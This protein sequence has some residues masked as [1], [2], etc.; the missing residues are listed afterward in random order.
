MRRR[1]GEAAPAQHD[2]HRRGDIALELGL[3]DARRLEILPVEIGDAVVPQGFERQ[4]A[5][6]GRR[7]NAEAGDLGEDI[8]AEHRRVPGDRRAPVMADNDGLLFAERRHQRDHVA[9]IVEDGVGVDIGRR[10]G[11]A[12][13]A[14]VGGDDMEAGFRDGRDLVPPGIG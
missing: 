12:E 10:A 9:D 4:A 13:A 14:H 6:A 2:S 8:G 11:P 7:R 3:G 1:I 5:S